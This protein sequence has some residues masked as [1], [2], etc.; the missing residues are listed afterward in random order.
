MRTVNC[1]AH[2][3]RRLCLLQ[4]PS[5]PPDLRWTLYSKESVCPSP[6]EPSPRRPPFAGATARGVAATCS[7]RDGTT[8][9]ANLPALTNFTER[10]FRVLVAGLMGQH[11]RPM[12]PIRRQATPNAHNRVTN[13]VSFRKDH[14]LTINKRRSNEARHP[15]P[16]PTA[17]PQ[18]LQTGSLDPNPAGREGDQSF[19]SCAR[20]PIT[21]T[22]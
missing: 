11:K 20:R 3:W 17:L 9:S 16:K 21:E 6:Q 2:S 19:S 1:A 15:L 7:V 5:G 13:S 8:G 22:V 14:F 18:E 4:V 10:S 12:H